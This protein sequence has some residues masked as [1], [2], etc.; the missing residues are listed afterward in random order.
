LR[1]EC[2]DDIQLDLP[3]GL[4]TNLPVGLNLAIKPWYYKPPEK[5]KSDSEVSAAVKAR[6]VLQTFV[7]ALKV[8]VVT[9]GTVK[10]LN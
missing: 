1:V 6:C 4:T 7:K 2:V 10:N 3:Q 5:R 9:V 8:V